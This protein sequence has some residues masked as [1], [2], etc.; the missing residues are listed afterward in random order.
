MNRLYLLL[1]L[2]FSSCGGRVAYAQFSSTAAHIIYGTSLPSVCKPGT[3]DVFFKTSATVGPYYCSAANTWTFIGAAAGG[4]VNGPGSSTNNALTIWDGTGGNLLKNSSLLF[5]GTTLSGAANISTGDG[6]VAGC[7]SQ[8]ELTSN[9][10]NF[11]KTCAPDAL[12]ADLTFTHANALPV[13]QNNGVGQVMRYPTPTSGVSTY[14]WGNVSDNIHSFGASFGSTS[15]GSSVLVADTSYFVVPYACII[16]AYNL[17]AVPA[18]AAVVV[19]VWKIATGTAV[20]TVSNTI[21]ASA[22]PSIASGTTKHSTTLTGWTTSVAAN[23]VIGI[24]LTT[25]ATSTFVSLV[26]QCDQ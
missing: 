18:S 8:L 23:D 25:V 26:L 5:D 20:P 24:A 2:I 4:A 1:L 11:R 17:T 19:D 22:T 13:T 16:S 9:G 10:S 15:S 6:T 3:G 12:T 21:T 7:D 14:T